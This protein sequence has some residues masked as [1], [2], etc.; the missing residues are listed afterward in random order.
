MKK[1][2]SLLGIAALLLSCAACGAKPA[3]ET[4]PVEQNG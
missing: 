1:I 4:T 2:L 3:A